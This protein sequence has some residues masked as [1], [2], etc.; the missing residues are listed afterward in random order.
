MDGMARPCGVDDPD[1]EGNRHIHTGI[2]QNAEGSVKPR[3]A[4]NAAG[5]I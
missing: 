3:G 2:L 4:V 5:A 1:A